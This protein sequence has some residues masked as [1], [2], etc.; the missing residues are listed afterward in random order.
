MEGSKRTGRSTV[1]GDET[2]SV[3]MLKRHAWMRWYPDIFSWFIPVHTG[4]WWQKATKYATAT[5]QIIRI[6]LKP[7][8][9][10]PSLVS[11]QYH[12]IKSELT[13]DLAFWKTWFSISMLFL[14]VGIPDVRMASSLKNSQFVIYKSVKL[15]FNNHPYIFLYFPTD[16]KSVRTEPL[17]AV[18]IFLLHSFNYVVWRAKVTYY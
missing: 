4:K 16:H 18:F 10:F 12:M 5:F 6:L 1:M 14:L 8:K 11:V 13:F 9:T 15:Q 7:W 2:K 3:H 17:H